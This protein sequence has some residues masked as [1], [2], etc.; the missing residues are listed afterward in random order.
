M[1]ALTLL[2]AGSSKNIINDMLRSLN[3]EVTVGINEKEVDKFIE[4]YEWFICSGFYFKKNY[5]KWETTLLASKIKVVV[6]DANL[7][8]K[9]RS[10]LPKSR[11]Y[12]MSHPIS[13]TSL[14]NLFQFTDLSQPSVNEIQHLK[15]LMAEDNIYNQA[16]QR[17][18]LD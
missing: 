7:Q 14:T 17:T 11:F 15:I 2:K 6:I 8:Q 16:F 13:R 1:K 5:P 3:C 10:L 18:L 4:Q 9:Y 12:I